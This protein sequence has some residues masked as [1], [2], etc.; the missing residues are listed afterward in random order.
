MKK[1][2]GIW[3]IEENWFLKYIWGFNSLYFAEIIANLP[4]ALIK[5]KDPFPVKKSESLPVTKSW[6]LLFWGSLLGIIVT[7]ITFF[8]G[9]CGVLFFLFLASTIIVI[10][11]FFGFYFGSKGEKSDYYPYKHWGTKKIPVAAWE[12]SAVLIALYFVAT[13][14]IE[15]VLILVAILVGTAFALI[16]YFLIPNTLTAI[17]RCI[18]AAHRRLCP[19]VVIE[20]KGE[21]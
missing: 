5:G 10:P 16:A 6:C 19:L 4:C 20:P 11:A 14:S 17:W 1:E 8:L 15:T 7:P 9:I 18:R 3:H 2:N 12:V 13:S 21:K